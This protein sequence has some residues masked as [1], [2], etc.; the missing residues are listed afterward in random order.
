[1]IS[2]PARPETPPPAAP[3]PPPPEEQPAR[4]ARSY[5][6]L[7]LVLNVVLVGVVA[8]ILYFALEH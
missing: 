7:I 6:P 5:L 2:A 8:I 4:T 1:V 3:A